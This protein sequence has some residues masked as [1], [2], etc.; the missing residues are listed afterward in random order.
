MFRII[1]PEQRK[2]LFEN[3]A[4][5]IGDIPKEIKLRHI[6]HCYKVDPEYERGLADVLGISIYEIET[7]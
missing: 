5:A 6:S 7:K 2:A 4:S 3:T 1:Y